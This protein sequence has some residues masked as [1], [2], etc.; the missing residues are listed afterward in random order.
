M[1][2]QLWHN[3]MWLLLLLL[4]RQWLLPVH[5]RR[6]SCH[7]TGVKWQ[8]LHISWRLLLLL[9]VGLLGQTRC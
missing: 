2:L 3:V 6:C 9:M 5:Q 4:R 7:S 8:L 1:L